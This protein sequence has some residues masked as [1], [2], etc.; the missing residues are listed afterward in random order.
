MNKSELLEL[1]D[2][3]GIGYSKYDHEPMYTVSDSE[4]NRII[5]NGL[6]TKNLFLKN[7]KNYFCLLS[8]QEKAVV[9]L[10]KFSKSIQAG[11]L[12]FANKDYLREHLGVEPGSVS[13]FGLINNKENNVDFYLDENLYCGEKINFHPLIN[14]ST[15]TIKIT[16]FVNFMIENNKKINIFSLEEYKVT[17][18]LWM[19]IKTL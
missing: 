15:I 12:S 5:V 18:V 7:K 6:H 4:K 14:T 17:K 3:K 13:P 9:N 19:M 16:E 11:N 8:C 2:N 1:L 10:K